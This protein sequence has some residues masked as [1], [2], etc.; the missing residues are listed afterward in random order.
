MEP[1]ARKRIE[2]ASKKI[3]SDVKRLGD[4]MKD[5]LLSRIVRSDILSSSQALAI[6]DGCGTCPPCIALNVLN[7]T[8]MIYSLKGRSATSTH[9]AP[10]A[11]QLNLESNHPLYWDGAFRCC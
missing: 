6:S 10:K 8:A 11:L 7:A 9:E 2:S 5:A 1:A 4:S 3:F